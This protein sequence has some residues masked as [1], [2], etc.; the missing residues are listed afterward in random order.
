MPFNDDQ[1]KTMTMAGLN[2]IGQALS[3]YDR[4]L[5]LV[6]SN[7]PFQALF[8]LPAE[9][10]TP[11]ATFLDTITHLVKRGEYGDVTDPEAFISERVEQARAFKP[12]Y[13]E[14]TRANGRTISVE[15]SPLAEGGWVTVYTD[16][17]A[18]KAQE[19]L[20]RARSDALSDQ[21]LAHTEQLSQTNREL[22]AMITALE[23]TKRQLTAAEARARLTTEM[24][25]AHIAH[26]DADGIYTYSNQR[27]NIVIP[28][29]PSEIL[30][31]HIRKVL[32]ADNHDKILGSLAAAYNGKAVVQ[33]FTD[34]TSAR[35]IRTALTP[36]KMGGVYILSMDITEET[37]T[38]AA[39]QQTSRRALAAQITSGLA[40]DFSNLLTIIL[41]MQSRLD[42]LPDL[43]ADARPLIEGT[44]AAARRGGTLLS[45]IAQVSDP[46]SL[47]PVATDLPSMMQDLVTLAEPTLPQGTRLMLNV[48]EIGPVLLDRGMLQ[49]GLL[50]LI[51]NARD[52]MG[53]G[54]SIFL[55]VRR[56][57]DTW[58]E[59]QVSDTGP[60][61]SAIAL[62]KGLDPFFTTKGSEGSGLGLPMVY[63]M[64]KLA[65]GDMHLANSKDGAQVTLRLPYRAAVPATTG[66]VLLVEDRD[67]LRAVLRDMLMELGHSVIEATSA[68]E[69]TALLADLPDI[70]LILSDLQLEGEATGID[71][72]RR[73]GVSSPPIVL[74][75]SLPPDAPLFLDAQKHAPVLRKPFTQG[76]LAALISPA[77]QKA[78]A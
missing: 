33:E 51:L 15:G 69:A 28:N 65:G 23:E 62:E 61:F 19:A 56:V 7:A 9:L 8:D 42:R 75:T 64:T 11:G 63:D 48:A 32:G 2:L 49:D 59:F 29:R 25:P 10:V 5:R 43:P 70:T 38:R 21:L 3:I 24:M 36:D 47:R 22:A 4:N 78:T 1:T 26:V 17:S 77:T 76:D 60:G 52:A 71:L 31:H 57:H 67:D 53:T 74:M 12:H 20:L 6:V 73:L 45:S 44:L 37:Q 39:L 27:L 46:R 41:G 72:V 35:R 18:T 55:D 40:H 50:N 30:G 68:D 58:I 14:R 34:S 16:I 54:G 66:L 13:M